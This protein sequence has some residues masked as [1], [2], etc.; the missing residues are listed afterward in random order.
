MLVGGIPTPPKNML[1]LGLLFPIYGQIK[2]V[3]NH[4]PVCV[5]VC[6]TKNQ[7]AQTCPTLENEQGGGTPYSNDDT[8]QPTVS[9]SAKPTRLIQVLH[10]T[11]W[12][13]DG[14]TTTVIFSKIICQT[15]KWRCPKSWGYH[16]WGM[17]HYKTSICGV[18]RFY[19]NAHRTSFLKERFQSCDV[20]NL[21]G[22][23]KRISTIWHLTFIDAPWYHYHL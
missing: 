4:Q 11:L 1:Q 21:G 16:C 9:I 5:C 22:F 6:P 7:R 8:P 18:P 3:P 19:G 14:T 10:K 15:N 12:I 23:P 20:G 13:L 17:F 2:H